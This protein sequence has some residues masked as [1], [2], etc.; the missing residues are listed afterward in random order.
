[1]TSKTKNMIIGAVVGAGV[2]AALV[3]LKKQKEKEKAAATAPATTT[4]K[5][6]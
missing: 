6:A 5:T 2:I 3:W 4:V 1:M